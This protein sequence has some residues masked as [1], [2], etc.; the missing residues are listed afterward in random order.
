MRR[1]VLSSQGCVL[2]RLAIRCRHTSAGSLT[3]PVRVEPSMNYVEV[4]IPFFILAI[5]LEFLYGLLARKQTYR[6]NDTVN[7]L[8]LGVLSRLVDIL[9]LGFAGIVFGTLV[10]W[11]G[12]PQWSMSSAWQW[13]AA[14]V[15]YDFFYYWKHRYVHE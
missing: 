9:R 14:F 3:S 7:S 12:L 13:V 11:A 10:Q 4:A 15:A 2:P 8:S 5:A 6:I 1:L